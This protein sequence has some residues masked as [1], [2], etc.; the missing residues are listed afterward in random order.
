MHY[1]DS[2]SD[3]K[4][5]FYTDAAI[6]KIFCSELYPT[7]TSLSTKAYWHAFASPSLIFIF[8]G[9]CQ[10]KLTGMLLH[11]V[12]QLPKHRNAYHRK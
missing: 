6:Y 10:Q 11:S 9:P 5:A 8:F 3:K 1:L 12:G 7:N 4:K 2:T